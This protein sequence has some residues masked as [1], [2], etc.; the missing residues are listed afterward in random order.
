MTDPDLSQQFNWLQ[1]EI[2]A[3]RA[4]NDVLTTALKYTVKSSP[5]AARLIALIERNFT[6]PKSQ[7]RFQAC[8]QTSI[9][10]HLRR[11]LA[12]SRN[13]AKF[14]H[15]LITDLLPIA[16][17]MPLPARSPQRAAAAPISMPT[18]QQTHPTLITFI[19]I[20]PG[21]LRC[22]AHSLLPLT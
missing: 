22:Q 9:G 14:R 16:H 17:L 11:P 6:K 21:L 4:R 7:R 8:H 18:A 15:A 13:G 10:M 20:P 1:A 3:L 5:Q 12:M 2:D 19:Q